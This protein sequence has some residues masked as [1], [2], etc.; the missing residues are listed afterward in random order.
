LAFDAQIDMPDTE[1]T[2]Y[3]TRAQDTISK[4]HDLASFLQM[5]MIEPSSDIN[6]TFLSVVYVSMSLICMALYTA[7]KMYDVS[8]VEG[9][10]IT[11]LPF[12]PCALW[13]MIMRVIAMGKQLA[14]PDNDPRWNTNKKRKEKEEKKKD[15]KDKV[16]EK[17]KESKKSK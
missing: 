5:F 1:D 17:R 6:F 3:N 11:L 13:S 14:Q 10:Y 16:K 15:N 12:I 7:E 4:G 2:K 8:S 9:Y